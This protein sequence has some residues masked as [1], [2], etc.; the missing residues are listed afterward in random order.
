[1]DKNAKLH[2]SK[3][4]TVVDTKS[5]Y[6]M[7]EFDSESSVFNN[8]QNNLQDMVNL[9]K[10]Y[11]VQLMKL[12]ELLKP[13]LTENVQ[14]TWDFTHQAAFDTIKEELIKTA[15]IYFNPRSDKVML[16]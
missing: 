5:S 12:P 3:H 2:D 13:Q 7:V 16:N 9:L 6:W 14:W 1:M 11:S 15:L 8:L 10:Y 4:L